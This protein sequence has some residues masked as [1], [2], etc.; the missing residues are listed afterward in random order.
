MRG[1]RHDSIA[2]PGGRRAKD[3][4][5]SG[6]PAV[7]SKSESG[8]GMADDLRQTA[9]PDDTRIDVDQDHAV[10]YWAEKLGLS[11]EQIE[12]AVAKV[13]SMVKNVRDHLQKR[14]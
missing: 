9:T 2:L 12:S 3:P 8:C 1:R 13:G 6:T 7:I 10:K 5:P 14:S 11:R 4:D